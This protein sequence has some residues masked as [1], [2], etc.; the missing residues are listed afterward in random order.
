MKKFIKRNRYTCILVFIFILFVILGL[1]VKDILIPDEGKAAYGDRDKYNSKHPISNDVY[2]KVD[3]ELKKNKNVID[4]THRLQGKIIIYKIVVDAKVSVKDAKTLGDDVLKN[5][6][7]DSLSYYT[8]RF[9]I[10]KEDEKLNN[11]PIEGTKHPK[12]KE[13]SWTKDREIVTE[14]EKNEE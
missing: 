1:K 12:S 3:E 2:S 4:I 5:F 11:F 13:I 14:S 9:N 8:F 7:E 6:S 10:V